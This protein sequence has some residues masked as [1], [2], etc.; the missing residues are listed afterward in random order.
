MDLA[1]KI[2]G[3]RKEKSWSQSK[4]AKRLELSREIVGRYE[5]SGAPSSIEITKR[6]AYAFEVSLDYLL[7]STEQEVDKATLTRLQG[8]GRLSDEN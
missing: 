7:G 6:M 1:S 4:L 2:T 8:I 5:R 3:G